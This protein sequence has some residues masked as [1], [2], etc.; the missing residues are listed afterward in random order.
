[1]T[2]KSVITEEALGRLV[3]RF[4]S[5]V[6]L[7]ALLG[8][9][10]NGAVE[11]WPEHLD[12]LQSFWSSV[13]LTSGRYKGR[14]LPAHLKH[15]AAMTAERFGRWLSLWE[16]TTGEMFEPATAAELQIKARR[17]GE[18][19]SLGIRFAAGGDALREMSRKSSPAFAGEGDQAKP[20][21]GVLSDS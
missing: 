12:R 13:M 18:S 20:G 10:F 19:L 21:G 8:P 4:Y 1:M 9:V 3:E 14:P 17:I 15:S 5:K 16:E 6:R 7:D 11:D 2:D